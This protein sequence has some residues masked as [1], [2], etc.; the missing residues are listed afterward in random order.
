MID[1]W[2]FGC[3]LAELFSGSLSPIAQYLQYFIFHTKTTFTI[4]DIIVLAGAV[5]A[6]CTRAYELMSLATP[7]PSAQH[8]AMDNCPFERLKQQCDYLCDH[9]CA[10]SRFIAKANMSSTWL[11]CMVITC[12]PLELGKWMQGALPQVVVG[13]VGIQCLLTCSGQTMAMAI[14]CGC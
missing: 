2:S 13:T 6:L 14:N 4:V 7:V 1:I 12:L 11:Y 5:P 3:I 9:L 8:V 10:R